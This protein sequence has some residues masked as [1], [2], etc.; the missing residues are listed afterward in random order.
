MSTVLHVRQLLEKMEALNSELSHS[1]AC[2]G[3]GFQTG[4]I[5]FSP[6]ASQDERFITHQKTD[7]LAYVVEGQGVL[8]LAD[9][10]VEVEPGTLCHIPAGTPHDFMAAN[11]D[12][13]LLYTSIRHGS[14]PG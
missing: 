13:V 8:R 7:V 3:P 10:R 14:S 9:Q 4:V 1:D 2:Q 5:R 12:L 6:R 11:G